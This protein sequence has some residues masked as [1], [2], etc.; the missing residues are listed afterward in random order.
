[1]GKKLFHCFPLL[2]RIFF[3]TS[4]KQ[5][6]NKKSFLPCR[7]PLSTKTT[8]TNFADRAFDLI[9]VPLEISSNRIHRRVGFFGKLIGQTSCKIFNASTHDK[10]HY[11]S[12]LN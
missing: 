7:E 12:L 1:M 4:F 11:D 3:F 10:W 9:G 2:P 8:T 6:E 5:T